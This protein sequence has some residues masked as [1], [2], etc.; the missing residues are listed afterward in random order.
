MVYPQ[1]ELLVLPLID[2]QHPSL[3]VVCLILSHGSTYYSVGVNGKPGMENL[4]CRNTQ[5]AQKEKLRFV[6]AWIDWYMALV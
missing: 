1:S 4:E 2:L 6:Y 5:N 3:P